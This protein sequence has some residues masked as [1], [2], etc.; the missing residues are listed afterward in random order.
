M[1]RAARSAEEIRAHP[2]T[3]HT[4]MRA[5]E[6]PVFPSGPACEHTTHN[7]SGACSIARG[8]GFEDRLGRRGHPAR[9]A[10]DGDEAARAA[11][12]P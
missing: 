3:L 6:G 4:W 7:D 12:D 5:A 11:L 2:P 1:K 10:A 8:Q 9:G